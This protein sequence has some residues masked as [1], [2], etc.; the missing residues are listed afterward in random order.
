MVLFDVF[1]QVSSAWK[2]HPTERALG[3]VAGLTV[4]LPHVLVETC[5]PLTLEI[6]L[7]ARELFTTVAL[8][9][10]LSQA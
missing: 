6:T 7:I 10:V 9:P 5:L 3:V 2:L 8:L 1:L 4:L